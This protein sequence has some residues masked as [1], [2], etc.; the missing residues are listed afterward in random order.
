MSDVV[1]QGSSSRPPRIPP[2]LGRV[3][4]VAVAVVAVALLGHQGLLSGSSS[5]EPGPTAADPSGRPTTAGARAGRPADVVVRE[6]RRLVRYGTQGTVVASRLPAGLAPGARLLGVDSGDQSSAFVLGVAGGRLFRADPGTTAA[7]TDVGS[8]RAVVDRSPDVGELFVQLGQKDGNRVVTVDAASGIVVDTQP[9]PGYDGAGGW[10]PRGAVSVYGADGMLL[11]RPTRGHEQEFAV[12]WAR[13]DVTAGRAAKVL[14]L[15]TRGRLLGVSSDWVLV[16]HGTCPGAGCR[17]EIVTVVA[18]AYATSRDVAPPRG[19]RFLP[20]PVGGR[21]HEV[22]V[23]VVARSGRT[24]ALARLVPGGA[25]ALLVRGSEGVAV[26]AGL[27]D[28]PDGDVYFAVDA[29]GV[30]RLAR[31]RPDS[32][33]SAALVGGVPSLP[34]GARL[35]CACG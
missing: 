15:H 10:R 22:L 32:P 20:G 31:W 19:W 9:F 24:R 16:M 3:L 13:R 30:R 17:L 23:P 11:G 26:E 33:S 14:A 34:P 28:E 2:R 27:V 21:S 4:V 12:A 29:A 35:A 6:G 8:A 7:A 25:D 5:P 1:E 18:T